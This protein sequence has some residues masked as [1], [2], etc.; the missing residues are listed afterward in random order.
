MLWRFMS[1]VRSA[2]DNADR[3]PVIYCAV[4]HGFIRVQEPVEPSGKLKKE[5]SATNPIIGS[6]T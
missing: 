5:P 1:A 4:D 3:D 2:C 6:Q